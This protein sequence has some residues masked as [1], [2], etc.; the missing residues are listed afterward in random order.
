MPIYGD[1]SLVK[2]EDGIL[3]I[4]MNPPVP[5]G[6]WD[7]R[8]RL[9]KRFGSDE[10]ISEKTVASGFN[11]QS[12]INITDSGQGRFRI[13]VKGSEMSGYDAGNYAFDVTRFT[14]GSR[15]TLAQGYLLLKE[16]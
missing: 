5:I 8:F 2:Y 9:S 1:F 6:A 15:T 14:S 13:T 7:I 4:N 11:N 10:L 16:G 3:T 12:G